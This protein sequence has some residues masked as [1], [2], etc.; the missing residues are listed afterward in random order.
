MLEFDFESEKKLPVIKVIGVGGGGNNAVNRMIDAGLVNV[1][2]VAANTDSQTL[3]LSRADIKLQLGM[4]L[5]RGRGAGANPEI[6][7]NAAEESREDIERTLNG[8]ELVFITAGMGGGTGTG[9]A[10][11]V[12]QMAKEAG[13]LTV[14][15][16]TK[17]FSFEGNKRHKQ[18]E[19]GIANLKEQV[20]ALIVIPNDR[21]L[22]VVD[23]NTSMTDA[24]KIADD[25]LRQGVQGIS[26]IIQAEG[27][28]NIS[29]DFADV[30]TIMKNT[31]AALMGI[32]IATGDNR[33]VNAVKAAF[34]SPLVESN[35]IEGAKGV[36]LNFTGGP[37]LTLFEANEAA[38]IVAELVDKDAEIIFGVVIDE[39]MGEEVKV[40][41]IATGFE[42]NISFKRGSGGS[43]SSE[44]EVPPVFTNI[45]LPEFLRERK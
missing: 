22:S 45:E 1:D 18:A 24:F 29:V 9:A 20:D 6:G 38:T 23:K 3:H 44:I 10:P 5:T 19:E 34:S 11:I 36:L 7:K 30:R 25:I 8:A 28:A 15:V 37:G 16:V 42:K 17:P 13:A 21:L 27:E 26:D 32:G 31:G 35:T 39:R 14:G 12:A 40:T 4:K 2:F 41:I 43:I 33:S